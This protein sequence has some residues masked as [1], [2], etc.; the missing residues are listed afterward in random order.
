MGSKRYL[1]GRG[2]LACTIFVPWDC[3]NNC[4][5]CTSKEMYSRMKDDFNL[6]EIINK[7]KI[8]NNNPIIHEYVLTGG[9]PLSNLDNLK[10]I[11]SAMDK[12]VYINTTLPKMET[13]IKIGVLK[14][15][16]ILTNLF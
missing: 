10:K 1:S 11:V 9:E 12:V 8:L 7:I 5:F 14:M 2:N 16:I 4:P 3:S 15:I 6:E 13:Y